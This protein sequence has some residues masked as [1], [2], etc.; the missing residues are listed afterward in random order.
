MVSTFESIP[1]ETPHFRFFSF[2]HRCPVRLLNST[3]LGLGRRRF[4]Q[5]IAKEDAGRE[6]PEDEK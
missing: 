2:V 3:P 6:E 4:E 1:A 5:K